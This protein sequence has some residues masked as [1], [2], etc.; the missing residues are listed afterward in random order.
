MKMEKSYIKIIDGHQYL[1]CSF[2]YAVVFHSLKTSTKNTALSTLKRNYSV[3]IDMDNFEAW[4]KRAWTDVFLQIYKVILPPYFTVIL[5]L[6][7]HISCA[8]I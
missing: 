3:N 8:I 5:L 4:S 7:I 1:L 2:I 6:F